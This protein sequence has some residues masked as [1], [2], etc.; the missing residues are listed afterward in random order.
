MSPTYKSILTWI[1]SDIVEKINTQPTNTLIRLEVFVTFSLFVFLLGGIF[2][3]FILWYLEQKDNIVGG[4]DKS[5]KYFLYKSPVSEQLQ[6]LTANR[7]F[8]LQN[9]VP[10]AEEAC[11]I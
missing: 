10:V 11:C 4:I 6:S 1:Q 5:E 3:L 2:Y 9:I 8:S 7:Q